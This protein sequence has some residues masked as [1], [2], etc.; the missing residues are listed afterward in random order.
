[1]KSFRNRKSSKHSKKVDLHLSDIESSDSGIFEI[2][3]NGIEESSE[4][5]PQQNN[6]VHDIKFE[7]HSMSSEDSS[8]S[9]AFLQHQTQGAQLIRK[10]RDST[11]DD[12]SSNQPKVIPQISSDASVPLDTGASSST[13]SPQMSEPAQS[14]RAP[15]VMTSTLRLLDRYKSA[16]K[17]ML[18]PPQERT[19]NYCLFR[20]KIWKKSS[21]RKLFQLTDS[22]TVLAGAELVS[23]KLIEIS[24]N[25]GQV[26]SVEITSTS[27]GPFTLRIGN[28]KL[29]DIY[30]SSKRAI[31]LQFYRDEDSKFPYSTLLSP[32]GSCEDLKK[33]FGDRK[34]IKSVKNCKL[35]DTD[36]KEIIAI[37]KIQKDALSIDA[38]RNISFLSCM[39]VGLFMFLSRP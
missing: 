23:S 10:R 14:E 17:L 30:A 18:C 33:A 11:S 20:K 34:V 2:Q 3:E 1:M 22:G 15:V 16:N 38:K 5:N 4:S 13:F 21:H 31:T 37:R 19:I 36:G 6:V 24:N 29:M 9:I 27:K 12:E 28:D 32:A 7:K 26:S 35:L 39:T 25:L 8:G